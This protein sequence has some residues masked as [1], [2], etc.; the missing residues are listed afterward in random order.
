M[1]SHYLWHHTVAMMSYRN[2]DITL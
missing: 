2:Y 1:T